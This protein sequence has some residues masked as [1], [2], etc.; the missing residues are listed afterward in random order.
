MNE[1]GRIKKQLYKNM[2]Y[3]YIVFIILFLLFDVIIYNKISGSMYKTVDEQLDSEVIRYS[4]SDENH[5]NRKDNP[6]PNSQN[7]DEKETKFQDVN[8]RFICIIR[9]SQG[10]VTNQDSIGR[11]YERYVT[12]VDFDSNNLEN[13]YM[14]K[15]DNQYNYRGITIKHYDENGELQYI[16]L[17]TNVD[18]EIQALQTVSITLI[19]G[20]IIIIVIS[21]IASY[22]LSRRALNPIME[23]WRKQTEF[24]QNASH[25]LRTP[26]TVI[27]AKQELLLQEPNK[28]IIDK[29]EDINISL[30]ETRRLSKLVKDLMILAR[31]DSNEVVLEK[32]NTDVD[33][34]IR[35]IL[36]P[37]IEFAELENKT[38]N[39]NLNCSKKINIDESRFSQLVVILLDNAIKYTSKGDTITINTNYTDNKFYLEVIDTGI[40]MSK[41]GIKHAFDRFYREDKARSREKGGSGLGLAIA[42]MITT[43]HGGVIKIQ[44]NQPK[45]TKV[46]VKI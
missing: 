40:G 46:I 20:T 6:P 42:Y 17:L 33:S 19:A 35:N 21:I 38:V 25:E 16:Q 29:S 3:I 37:Y 7:F 22:L 2:F 26:L 43:L 14:V 24:V 4:D 30:N 11:M 13:K 45:G 5:M 18:G 27:Q 36:T 32:K 28:K 44:Q 15:L 12:E 1:Q 9:D 34:L 41:E 8:P 23:S 39:M 31:S 10:K